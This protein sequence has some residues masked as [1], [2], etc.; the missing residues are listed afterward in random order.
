MTTP[1]DCL[2]LPKGTVLFSEGDVG[3]HAY[4][5]HSGEIEIIVERGGRRHGDAEP[6]EQGAQSRRAEG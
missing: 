4:L 2:F 3:D 1:L 5:I 6:Q